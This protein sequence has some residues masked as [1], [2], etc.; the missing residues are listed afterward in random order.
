MQMDFLY[1]VQLRRESA[2]RFNWRRKKEYENMCLS[3]YFIKT[4]QYTD[5]ECYAKRYFLLPAYLIFCT[6]TLKFL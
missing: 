4:T 5:C 2:M 6:R 1:T 3:Y